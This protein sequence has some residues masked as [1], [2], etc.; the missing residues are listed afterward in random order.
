MKVEDFRVL[1]NPEGISNVADFHCESTKTPRSENVNSELEKRLAHVIRPS[2]QASS[3]TRS[4]GFHSGLFFQ[5]PRDG[6]VPSKFLS[7]FEITLRVAKK[8][9][10]QTP[11]RA[12]GLSGNGQLALSCVRLADFF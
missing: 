7:E 2:C 8:I 6:A 12:E 1:S 3:K 4:V 9:H 11:A 10:S 5:P